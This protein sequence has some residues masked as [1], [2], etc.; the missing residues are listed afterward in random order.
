MLTLFSGTI[1]DVPSMVI[2]LDALRPPLIQG[3]VPPPGMTPGAS[4]ARLNGFRLE[5]GRS[6]IALLFTTVD[7]LDDSVVSWTASADTSTVVATS[8]TFIAISRVT[9]WATFTWMLFW[10]YFW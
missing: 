8:P 9:V 4:V 6:R 3:V 10:K 5:D 2:S 1:T 7:T